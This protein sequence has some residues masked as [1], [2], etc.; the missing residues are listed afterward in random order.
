M[1]HIA[2]VRRA[3]AI[4]SA[5]ALVLLV[6]AWTTGQAD[7]QPPPAC[8]PQQTQQQV[9]LTTG[10]YSTGGD[11][12]ERFCGPGVLTITPTGGGRSM[13]IR[14]GRCGRIRVYRR[15]YFGLMSNGSLSP[16]LGR[17]ASLVLEP[18][19]RSGRVKVIDGR[20]QPLAVEVGLTGSAMVAPDLSSGTFSV[21]T[22]G[23]LGPG[24]NKAYT[25]NWK[26]GANSPGSP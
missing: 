14:G 6:A 17:G 2:G 4:V 1:T 21:V 7:V 25:G 23:G 18:G 12:Y 15:V 26:C 22:R 8:S 9:T 19:N 20:L 11:S 24:P 16:E 10:A 5:S 3:S 13:T